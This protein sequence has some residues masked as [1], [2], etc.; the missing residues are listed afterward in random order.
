MTWSWQQPNWPEWQYNAATLANKEKQFLLQTG[1]LGGALSHINADDQDAIT[2]ELLSNEAL[3][4]SEIEGE[5]L[6]RASV[7]SSIQREFGLSVAKKGGRREA[8]M[9]TLMHELHTSFDKP[10]SHE[11]LHAWH[12]LICGGQTGIKII[13]AYRTGGDPMQIVSG[14]IQRPVIHFEAPPSA[15]LQSEMSAFIEWFNDTSIPALE[16]AA[17]AHL[18]FV[19]IHPYEDGNGRIARALS[20]KALAQSLGQ[21]SLIALSR[22]IEKHRNTYYDILASN[23]QSLIIDSWMDWFAI[24]CLEAQAY[25]KSL[26]EHIVAK[27]KLLDRLRDKLNERQKKVLLRM[28]DAGPEGFAGGLS[29]KNYLTI[30]GTTTATATRD[31]RDLVEKGAL[32][33]TGSQKGT[34]YWLKTV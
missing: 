26:V 8:G 14:P 15:N 10:L 6:D 22:T 7:Q 25:S 33:R 28:F 13:G 19:S 9:A 1:S 2:I 27:A 34:R 29:A 16:K 32:K 20:Q 11:T 4:T 17:L 24:A 21:P 5:Y 31:L 12:A 23:N 30:T 18:W 3:K